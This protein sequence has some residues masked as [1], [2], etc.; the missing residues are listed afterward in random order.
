MKKYILLVII[1]TFCI[2]VLHAKWQTLKTNDFTIFYCQNEDYAWEVINIL[3]HY[4]S[5]PQLFFGQQKKNVPIVIE[6]L[7]AFFNAYASPIFY[8]IHLFQY[9]PG[10]NTLGFTQNHF[11]IAAIHEYTHILHTTK[12][13]GT[14]AALNKYFGNLFLPNLF[15]PLWFI[16]GAAVHQE[17]KQSS[18]EGA[19][20]DGFYDAYI[21]ALVYDNKLPKIYKATSFPLEFPRYESYYLFGGKFMDF[22]IKKYGDHKFRVF[23]EYNS[24]S[25]STFFSPLVPSLGMDKHAKKVYGKSFDQ[26]W[27]VWINSEKEKYSDFRQTGIK[28]TTKGWNVVSLLKN[29]YDLYYFRSYPQKTNLFQSFEFNQIVKMDAKT[30]DEKVIFSANSNFSAHPKIHENKL[31]FT[32]N[33]LK[34]GYD[35]IS[36]RTFGYESVLYSKN[37]ETGEVER[38][39]KEKIRAFEVLDSWTFI[40][41]KDRKGTFGTD[42]FIYD[43]V[44]REKQFLF[45]TDY[46]INEIVKKTDDIYYVSAR[47][48]WENFGIYELS[49]DSRAFEQIINTDY[50]ETNIFLNGSYLYFAANYDKVHRTY[51]YDFDSR[52]LFRAN[53][54]FS[55]CPTMLTFNG[56][57]GGKHLY[58]IG[59]NSNGYDIYKTP[60][61]LTKFTLPNLPAISEKPAFQNLNVETHNTG[62]KENLK[63]LY[64]KIRYPFVYVDKDESAF[65]LGFLG[66]DALG[67]IPMYNI[68]LA[69]DTKDQMFKS[70]STINTNFFTPFESSFEYN[71]FDDDLFRFSIGYPVIKSLVRKVQKLDVGTFLDYYDDFGRREI[72]PFVHG[73]F[74]WSK[75][76]VNYLLYVPYEPKYSNLGEDRFGSYFNFDIKQYI[77]KSELKLKIKSAYDPDNSDEVL[78]EIRGYRDPLQG[79]KGFIYALEYSMPLLKIRKGSWNPNAY[80]EDMIVTL[81]NDGALDGS[82]RVQNT[83]GIELHFET[84]LFFG[85]LPLDTGISVARNRENDKELVIF[86][87]SEW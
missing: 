24:G 79:K 21:A 11:R 6:D 37:L 7:G 83:F 65:G 69:Y 4:K 78:D 17:S 62:L 66:A 40:Y 32:L 22:L 51:A 73:Q 8:N 55:K 70:I 45:Q 31:F 67:Y 54:D 60:L 80:V 53:D 25:F 5:G 64:P 38:I 74:K 46:L 42:I 82:G 3:E 33:E 63:T 44:K 81:F 48:N 87:K 27:Q 13:E 41:S 35:N 39:L 72:A 14:L 58:Y 15:A 68:I 36:N 20:N 9:A 29:G 56:K 47:R 57:Y 75:T 12:A 86:I 26:L 84:T 77:Y 28:I 1:F 23:M 10:F 50:S 34:K 85:M 19:L 49:L 43:S 71:N 16:E 52:E 18:F 2:T 59:L 30:S 76:V 61:N